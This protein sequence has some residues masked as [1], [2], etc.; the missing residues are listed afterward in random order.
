MHAALHFT[1]RPL[2]G[3]A[4][5]STIE[6]AAL[7]SRILQLTSK[8]PHPAKWLIYNFISIP[9]NSSIQPFRYPFTTQK[10]LFC[11]LTTHYHACT[12][13][14]SMLSNL[15]T[16]SPLNG[17]CSRLAAADIPLADPVE[18]VLFRHHLTAAGPRQPHLL[19]VLA[20]KVQVNDRLFQ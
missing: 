8:L 16:I 19:S 10:H 14:G 6:T 9:D 11:S 5:Y 13:Q 7:F 12:C 3:N 15:L 20:R 4:C 18:N 17:I 2:P 1:G